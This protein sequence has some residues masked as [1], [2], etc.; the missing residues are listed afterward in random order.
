MLEEKIVIGNHLMFNFIKEL[1]FSKDQLDILKQ[2]MSI[3]ISIEDRLSFLEQYLI[4]MPIFIEINEVPTYTFSVNQNENLKD[5]IT[6][7]EIY[8]ENLSKNIIKKLPQIIKDDDI[9]KYVIFPNTIERI[10]EL[11]SKVIENENYDFFIELKKISSDYSNKY[12]FP[13]D[14]KSNTIENRLN[15]LKAYFINMPYFIKIKMSQIFL[16]NFKKEKNNYKDKIQNLENYYNNYIIH[17]KDYNTYYDQLYK[18]QD[19][20]RK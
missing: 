19:K 6:S 5:R 9:N 12:E 7:L 16:E 2:N 17:I 3:N 1:P 14:N 10:S 20:F 8:C 11:E 15:T 18:E 4:D 13:I